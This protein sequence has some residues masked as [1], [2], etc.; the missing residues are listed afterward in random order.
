MVSKNSVIIYFAP[1]HAAVIASTD[2]YKPISILVG[3]IDGLAETNKSYLETGFR[4]I[5]HNSAI[6]LCEGAI[7]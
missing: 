5:S 3:A 4:L 6:S 1:D 7:E 2:N